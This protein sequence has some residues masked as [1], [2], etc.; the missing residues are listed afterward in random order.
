MADI[1]TLLDRGTVEVIVRKELE[2]KLKEGE[3]IKW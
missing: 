3:T 2:E 1:E